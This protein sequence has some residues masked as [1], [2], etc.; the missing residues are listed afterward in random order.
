MKTDGGKGREVGG[1]RRRGIFT[2]W[3][4]MIAELRSPRII[5]TRAKEVHNPAS[6]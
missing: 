6:L 5:H 2:S 3:R 1:E 4:E